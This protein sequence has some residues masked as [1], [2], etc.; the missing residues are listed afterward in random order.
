MHRLL[1]F[2]LAIMYAMLNA[3]IHNNKGRTALKKKT[4]L[5][6]IKV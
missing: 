6:D 4:W 1:L 3:A 5:S 2:N